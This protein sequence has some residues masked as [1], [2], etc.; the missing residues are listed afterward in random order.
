MRKYTL[1]M[2]IVVHLFGVAGFMLSP[3]FATT[4]LPDP[5]RAIEFIEVVGSPPPMPPPL[6]RAEP[7]RAQTANPHAAPIA[8]PAEITPETGF[9]PFES[10]GDP[11]GVPNGVVSG[12]YTGTPLPEVTAPPAP[13]PPKEPLRVGGAILEPQKIRNVTPVYPLIAQRASVQGVVILEAV[14]G[15]E[16]RIRNLRVL[17]SIP[18]L[19]QAAV[20]AVRQWLFTPTLLNGEPVPVVMTVTVAFTLQR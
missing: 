4:E 10:A 19:D 6:R 9:E 14:I 17:R 15:E 18:L 13:P 8:A 1:G 11:Q 12:I 7:A 20:D 5:R 3:I 2:S 16:G